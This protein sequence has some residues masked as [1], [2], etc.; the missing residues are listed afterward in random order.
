M[1]SSFYIVGLFV[2]LLSIAPTP[3]TA[4]I[5]GTLT[6]DQ[7]AITISPGQDVVARATLH[8][9]NN[10]DALITDASD[11]ILGHGFPEAKLFAPGIGYFNIAD[12]TPFPDAFADYSVFASSFANLDLLPGHDLDFAIATLK[13][14]TALTPGTYSFSPTIGFFTLCSFASSCNV[15]LGDLF[16]PVESEKI[17]VAS[18]VPEPDSVVLLAVG[19]LGVVG[20]RRRSQKRDLSK[21]TAA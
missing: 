7:S 5:I 3:A 15:F 11:N 20:L 12:P 21:P 18:A 16:T 4:D 1:K 13:P 9:A 17:T 6:L 8:L 10:S 19:L 2:S 14:T